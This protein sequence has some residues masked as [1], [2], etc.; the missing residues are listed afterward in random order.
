MTEKR[1]VTEGCVNL[2][3]LS[4]RSLENGERRNKSEEYENTRSK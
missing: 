1:G 2:L 4:P 3:I